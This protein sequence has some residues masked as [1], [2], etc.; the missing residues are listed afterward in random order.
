MPAILDFVKSNN[1]MGAIAKMMK[2]STVLDAANIWGVDVERFGINDV[3]PEGIS[4]ATQ[5]MKKYAGG[6]RNASPG[7]ALVGDRGPEFISMQGGESVV[8][9]Q[10]TAQILRGNTSAA[11]AP[12]IS[13]PMATMLLANTPQNQA[14]SRSPMT[15]NVNFDKGSICINAGGSGN[16][17]TDI[18]NGVQ[19]GIKQAMND[20]KNHQVIKSIAQ[21]VK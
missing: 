10:E 11:Q 5:I 7:L 4:I 15:L 21:G 17:A 8:S 16:A 19:Q 1:D 2:A 20:L 12:W 9:A 13:S 3:H 14:H 6:T 18:S